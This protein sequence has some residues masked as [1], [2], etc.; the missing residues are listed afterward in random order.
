MCLGC[1]LINVY[2]KV[3]KMFSYAHYC[4]NN[5][6]NDAVFIQIWVSILLSFLLSARSRST[7]LIWNLVKLIYFCPC[8]AKMCRKKWEG[9]FVIFTSVCKDLALYWLELHQSYDLVVRTSGL[10]IAFGVGLRTDPLLN[11]VWG[12]DS[13]LSV[14]VWMRRVLVWMRRVLGNLQLHILMLWHCHKRAAY[15]QPHC[16]RQMK[17]T[18][19]HT[20]TSY[21]CHRNRSQ[22]SEMF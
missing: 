19:I 8:F 13:S 11:L 3:I 2:H 1:I 15:I 9:I 16:H 21:G 4:F 20:P 7:D 6:W 12:L 22:F 17:V 10:E 5:E 18:L 14:N